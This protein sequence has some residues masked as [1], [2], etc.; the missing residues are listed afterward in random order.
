[1]DAKYIYEPWKAPRPDQKKAGVRVEGNGLGER[2]EGTYPRPMFDFGERREVC[3]A[4]MKKAYKVGLQ[5][6]DGRVADGSWR[7]LFEGDGEVEGADDA[8]PAKS[9]GVGAQEAEAD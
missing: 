2:V 3:I 6:N 1:M 9:V 7:E 5:G 4:A 8:T